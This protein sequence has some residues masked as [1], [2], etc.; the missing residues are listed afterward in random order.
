MTRQILATVLFLV[1]IPVAPA[2]EPAVE[3]AAH[4]Q[5]HA[6]EGRKSAFH[7]T[8]DNIAGAIGILAAIK[9][10]IAYLDQK[11]TNKENATVIALAEKYMKKEGTE[12]TIANISAQLK[13][14]P[15]LA[16]RAILQEQSEMTYVVM[17]SLEIGMMS[18]TII[19]TNESGVPVHFAWISGAPWFTA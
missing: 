6:E 10:V 19:E 17:R 4:A 9:A 8:F 12:E 1:V 11:R 18:D 5:G 15:P 3:P 13:E 14:M 2:Q 7:P 16:R